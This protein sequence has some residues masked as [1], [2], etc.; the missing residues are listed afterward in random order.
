MLSTWHGAPVSMHN[1]I[2]G[3]ELPVFYIS[4]LVGGEWPTLHACRLIPKK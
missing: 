1:S 4:A 2:W 3:V